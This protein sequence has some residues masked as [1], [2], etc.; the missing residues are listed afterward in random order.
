MTCDSYY[1]TKQYTSCINS[2]YNLL[3][4]D[5]NRKEID[6]VLLTEYHKKFIFR[7]YP[8]LDSPDFS[9]YCNL[10]KRMG[11]NLDWQ[12]NHG[13]IRDC[14][15]QVYVDLLKKNDDGTQMKFLNDVLFSD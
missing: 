7:F 3:T 4:I 8:S 12:C 10:I 2:L 6:D 15:Q 1:K 5:K 9:P 13:N 11:E 14:L